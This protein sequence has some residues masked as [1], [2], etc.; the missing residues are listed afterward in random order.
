MYFSFFNDTSGNTICWDFQFVLELCKGSDLGEVNTQEIQSYLK[1]MPV[2][3]A[4]ADDE[5]AEVKTTESTFVA[6]VQSLLKD[7]A[8]RAYF[9]QVRI[10]YVHHLFA[11][12]QGSR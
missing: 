1:R 12:I 11:L 6:L 8:E 7:P 9:F 2:S 3:S 10:I 5:D 4:N